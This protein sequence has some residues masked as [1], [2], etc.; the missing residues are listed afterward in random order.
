MRRTLSTTCRPN[1]PSVT[2]S[3]PPA[4]DALVLMAT[5]WLTNRLPSDGSA[6]TPLPCAVTP[7]AHRKSPSACHRRGRCVRAQ[8]R[9]QRLMMQVTRPRLALDKCLYFTLHDAATTPQLQAWAT[10]AATST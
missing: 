5:C 3:D 7:A 1:M 9:V 4:P 8:V 2:V 6:S 10:S